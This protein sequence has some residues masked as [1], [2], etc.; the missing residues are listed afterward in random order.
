MKNKLDWH[1]ECLFNSESYAEKIQKQAIKLTKEASELYKKN[2]HYR[3]QIVRAEMMGKKS[4]DRDKF[5]A[6]SSQS[7]GGTHGK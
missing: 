2:F 1:R 3:K 6:E 7:H 4:F 5:A